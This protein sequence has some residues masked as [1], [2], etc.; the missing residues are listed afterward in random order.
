M[1]SS[2][3]VTLSSGNKRT[4]QDQDCCDAQLHASHLVARAKKSTHFTRSPQHTSSSRK[5]TSKHQKMSDFC[6]GGSSPAQDA[7]T[8]ESQTQASYCRGQKMPHH[9]QY[10][11]LLFWYYLLG[12][13]SNSSPS[14]AVGRWTAAGVGQHSVLTGSQFSQSLMGHQTPKLFQ[15]L[16]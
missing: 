14:Q 5:A 2:I 6:W 3:H 8:N 16:V 4:K 1:P 9:V 10:G 15:N 7:G 11:C 13:C 12:S